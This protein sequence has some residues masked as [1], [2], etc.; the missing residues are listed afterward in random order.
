MPSARKKS[1][2][3]PLPQPQEDEDVAGVGSSFLDADPG[4]DDD[5]LEDHEIADDPFF[6][7]F[8]FPSTTNIDADARQ[9]EEPASPE[10]LDSSTD[11]EGP[12]SPTSRHIRA[13]PDSSV[14]PL[15]SP[16]SPRAPW[17]VCVCV[18]PWCL[19]VEARCKA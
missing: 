3:D 19:A 16:L 7:R 13:R 10:S 17:K 8:N 18:L 11:N 12:L 6:T 15:G 4:D 9:D 2:T 5:I 1:T 14:E